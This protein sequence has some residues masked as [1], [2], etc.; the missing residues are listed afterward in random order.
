VVR[1]IA[2]TLGLFALFAA[3][4]VGML[5]AVGTFGGDTSPTSLPG[6]FET[7]VEDP[8]IYS[9]QTAAIG[10]TVRA[11]DVSWTV[12]DARR[13]TELRKYTFPRTTTHGHFV[14]VSF[15]VENTSEQPVTLT[16][17]AVFLL[18]EERRKYPARAYL[19]SPYVEP[20]KDIL[21]T[22]RSLLKPGETREGRVN[23]AVEPGASGFK[24]QL[25]DTDP[26]VDEER[27]VDLGF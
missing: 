7:I 27:F 11:G 4:V 1:I 14:V 10:E 9:A 19:N 8:D 16:E 3:A 22:E 15:T 23:F 17:D 6:G 2:S 26:T 24:I 25:G 12:T 13:E 21:F 20:E 18:D 5:A